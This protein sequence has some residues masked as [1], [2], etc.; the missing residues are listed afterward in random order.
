MAEATLFDEVGDSRIVAVVAS[1][2]GRWAKQATV[3]N[4]DKPSAFHSCMVRVLSAAGMVACADAVSA[5]TVFVLG[6]LLVQSY[7]F[8][9]NGSKP[10][11]IHDPLH[12]EFFEASTHFLKSQRDPR[13]KKL[14]FISM[15]VMAAALL[16]QPIPISADV[17]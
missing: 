7:E 13:C 10:T 4:A 6:F 14:G 15:P 3:T 17:L 9:N 11:G 8:L 5:E 16:L 2:T 12:N 1:S